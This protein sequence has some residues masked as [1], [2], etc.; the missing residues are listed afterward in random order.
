MS[1][2][3]TAAIVPFAIFL[4]SVCILLPASFLLLSAPAAAASDL[5][6]RV[7]PTYISP[8]IAVGDET[9]EAV[10][11]QNSSAYQI[12]VKSRIGFADEP[13]AAISLDR[14]EVSLK[15]G[16]STVVYISIKVPEDAPSGSRRQ[17][18]LFD[19]ASS[20]GADLAV[21]GRVGM[22]LDLS[23]I[24]PV[25]DVRWSFPHIIDST[26]EVSFEAS[27]RNA[28]NFTTRLASRVDL[29]SLFATGATLSSASDPLPV[30]QTAVV[31]A[32]WEE[33][34]VFSAER[35]ELELGSGV[36]APVR[37][38]TFLIVFPW[39]LS[40]MLALMAATAAAGAR[41]QPIIAK[42][43]APNGRETVKAQRGKAGK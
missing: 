8:T 33:A 11:L 28:G 30:G 19:T 39:K 14:E 7:S 21:V 36:G 43:L 23:I 37:S 25:E 1:S 6:F 35:A 31:K 27:G 3:R 5:G 38:S 13:A 29:T 15:P 41:F 2:A 4:L 9:R 32:V 20:S 12:M 22:E 16:E 10:T 17:T 42:V 24:H 26:E 18:I 40:L 34:P